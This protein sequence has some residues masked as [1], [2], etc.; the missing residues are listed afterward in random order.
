MSV[1]YK[2]RVAVGISD[3]MGCGKREKRVILFFKL[4]IFL[5]FKLPTNWIKFYFLDFPN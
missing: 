4:I 3:E 5:F 2:S 1:R